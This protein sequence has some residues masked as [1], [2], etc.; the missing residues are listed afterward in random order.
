M[1][2]PYCLRD[3]DLVEPGYC[4]V[5]GMAFTVEPGG[6]GTVSGRAELGQQDSAV[7]VPLRAAAKDN[8]PL[9]LAPKRA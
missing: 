1:Q 6:L 9:Q 3:D 2:C 5:C 4:N 8:M 7:G